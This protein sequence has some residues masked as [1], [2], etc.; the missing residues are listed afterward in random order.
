MASKSALPSLAHRDIEVGIPRLDPLNFRPGVIRRVSLDENDFGVFA[1][2]RETV[3][4]FFDISRFVPRGNDD[5]NCFL[6]KGLL[7]RPRNLKGD[8]GKLGKKLRE[9]AT[10]DFFQTKTG[11]RHQQSARCLITSQPATDRMLRMWQE[12]EQKRPNR[13]RKGS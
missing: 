9:K 10:D 8:Q 2:T 3:H 5:R 6:A 13:E 4:R 7:R 1:E 12:R 11:R